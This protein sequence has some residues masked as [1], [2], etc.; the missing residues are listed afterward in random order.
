MGFSLKNY[1]LK[2]QLVV[3]MLGLGLV[4]AFTIGIFSILKAS[5]ALRGSESNA[6]ESVRTIQS[7]RLEDYFVTLA[8]GH[9]Y[10]GQFK[11]LS[12]LYTSTMEFAK[13]KGIKPTDNFPVSDPDYAKIW[14]KDGVFLKDLC[15]VYGYFDLMLV[16]KDTGWVV[17]TAAKEPDNGENIGQGSSKLKSEGL[18]ICYKKVL[19]TGKTV[20]VDFTSYSPS[21]GAAALFI[22]TPAVSGGKQYG[23]LVGQVSIDVINGILQEAAGMGKSG[24]SYLV[25]EDK[26]M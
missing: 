5:S 6:L 12:G 19:E 24:E 9:T 21:K 10:L 13:V 15:E 14:D 8:K 25:G 3:I 2:V 23:V 22:G 20:L 1:S 7:N 17:A 18:G 26:K 4:V 11:K 16:D